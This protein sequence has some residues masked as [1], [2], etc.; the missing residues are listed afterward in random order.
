MTKKERIYRGRTMDQIGNNYGMNIN[1]TN[2]ISRIK[3]LVII[4]I[5]K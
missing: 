5:D 1:R 4:E 2:G 3:T